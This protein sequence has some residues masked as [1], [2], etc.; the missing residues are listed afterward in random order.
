MFITS[1]RYAAFTLA[2]VLITLTV[3]GIVASMTIPGIIQSSQDREYKTAKDKVRM[4]IA[5]AGKVLSVQGNIASATSAEDFVKN[6]LS[7]TLSIIKFCAPA[8]MEQCGMPSGGSTKFKNL[9]NE[10]VGP[11]PTTWTT[12]TNPSSV[13][14]VPTSDGSGI[15]SSTN[16]TTQN[17]NNSYTFLTANGISVNLFYNPL[18]VSTHSERPYYI[19]ST[20]TYIKEKKQVSLDT[21]CMAGVYDMNGLKKPNQVGRD[22]GFFA[23]FYNGYES[24]TA[25][26]LP[27]KEGINTDSKNLDQAQEY[28]NGIDLYRLPSLDELSTLYLGRNI[29]GIPS[30]VWLWSGSPVSGSS[31]V[32]GVYFYNGLR[33]WGYRSDRIAVRCVRD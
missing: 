23:T 10:I 9:N 7:K 21:A 30:N 27:Y 1:K 33:D 20:E 29:T 32:R 24:T 16:P 2:E 3:I 17:Y 25:S 19:N 18:C 11:M 13:T 28:C 4:S 5:E 15:Y 31:Y 22:I 6:Y 12:I 14:A 8:N 26:V